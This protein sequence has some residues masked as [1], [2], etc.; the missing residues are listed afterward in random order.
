MTTKIRKVKKHKYHNEKPKK[1]NGSHEAKPSLGVIVQTQDGYEVHPVNKKNRTIFTLHADELGEAHI[2]DLVRVEFVPKA[3]RRKKNNQHFYHRECRIIDIISQ[4]IASN[5]KSLGLIAANEHHIPIEF[6]EDVLKEA[7]QSPKIT[8]DNRMDMTDFPFITIDP[9]D[10]RDHDDAVYALPDTDTSNQGGHIVYVAIADVAFYVRSGS[11]LDQEARLR[12][13]SVY[14]PDRVIPMLPEKLSADLCSLIENKA[15]PALVLKM[16]FNASGEKI[17]H[18]FSRAMIQCVANLSYEDVFRSANGGI[19]DHV[20]PFIEPVIK[21]LI[22]SYECVLQARE[23]RGPLNLELPEYHIHLDEKGEVKNITLRESLFTHKLIEEFMV[24]A[25]VCAAE[26]LEKKKSVVIYRSHDVPPR[27]K[28]ALLKDIL[29]D[30][31]I[32]FSLGQVMTSRAFNGVLKQAKDTEFQELVN[33]LILRC[34]CQAIYST[35]NLGHFGLHLAR[36]AHFTSPIRRYA[37]LFIHRALITALKLGDD[38]LTDGDIEQAQDT[39]QHISKTERIAMQIEMETKDRYLAG[40]MSNKIGT[41]FGAVVSGVSNAGLFIKI[42]MFGA[43]GLIPI[44][45]LS[46]FKKRYFIFDDKKHRL[47]DRYTGDYY[48]LG[49]TIWV[50]LTEATPMTGGMRFDLMDEKNINI[51]PRKA[52]KKKEKKPRIRVK[53]V[54]EAQ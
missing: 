15:R 31:N 44:A 8:N 42:T 40:F 36:Y 39:A 51:S 28:L 20:A 30:M 38:G 2:G 21:P 35:E 13:N 4:N 5:A 25:N 33:K 19:E 41:E 48:T 24:L 18:T 6:P 22:A 10:A 54:N 52:G 17:S 26:T 1:P 11:G 16:R 43:E 46:H 53:K 7:N 45:A 23:K 29:K 49:Q 27:D 12:G 3:E 50:K 47:T 34:Q 37:D 32:S 14:L 9:S